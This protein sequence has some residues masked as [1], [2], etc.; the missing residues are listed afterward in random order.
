MKTR[1]T[2]LLSLSLSGIAA[3]AGIVHLSSPARADT[4]LM[5]FFRLESSSGA[6]EVAIG[7]NDTWAMG[8]AFLDP[9]C[10]DPPGTQHTLIYKDYPYNWPRQELVAFPLDWSGQIFDPNPQVNYV[11]LEVEYESVIPGSD[12]TYT[13]PSAPTYHV[14]RYWHGLCGVRTPW[15][16]LFNELSDGLLEEIAEKAAEKWFISSTTRHYD[17][18]APMFHGYL[19]DI[20]HGFAIEAEYSLNI[21]AL[22]EQFYINPAYTLSVKKSNGMVN[23]THVHSGVVAI[24]DVEEVI[25]PALESEL[26]AALEENIASQMRVSLQTGLSD[27]TCDP[28]ADLATQQDTCFTKFADGGGGDSV[29]QV[30]FEKALL[31]AG[32]DDEYSEHAAMQMNRALRKKN[33]SCQPDAPDSKFGNCFFNPVI[34]RLNVLPNYLEMVFAPEFEGTLDTPGHDLQLLYT[35]LPLLQQLADP[36]A[37]YTNL[38][39][40][41]WWQT[42]SETTYVVHGGKEM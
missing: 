37:D 27:S 14:I 22:E 19:D 15:T 17:K 30:F 35:Y 4:A 11:P 21:G 34:M 41:P 12:E 18:M 10:V 25:E 39:W 2:I 23:V 31:A 7:G 16:T 32:Y 5:G 38:C 40:N 6:A 1:R 26:P 8:C 3:G 13:F 36:N 42:G 20:R 29:L 9:P 33:F 28:T 24:G